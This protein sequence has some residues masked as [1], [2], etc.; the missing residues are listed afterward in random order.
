[1]AIDCK[2]GSELRSELEGRLDAC[3]SP[4]VTAE[5][6]NRNASRNSEHLSSLYRQKNNAAAT[7]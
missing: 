7:L 2:D 6:L 1:M 3:G 5:P 4:P